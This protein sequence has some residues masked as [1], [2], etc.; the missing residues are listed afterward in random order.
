MAIRFQVVEKFAGRRVSS[1]D[2][3][4]HCFVHEDSR[5]NP[6]APHFGFARAAK[7]GNTV[8]DMFT[9]GHSALHGLA[10]IVTPVRSRQRR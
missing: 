7:T 9:H 4:S 6:N 3:S 2:A 5:S 1:H 8:H 10:S